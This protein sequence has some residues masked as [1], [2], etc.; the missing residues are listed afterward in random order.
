MVA[1]ESMK[2]VFYIDMEMVRSHGVPYML[3][4][5]STGFELKRRTSRGARNHIPLSAVDN[6]DE[7]VFRPTV[8]SILEGTIGWQ[9]QHI[10]KRKA[11]IYVPPFEVSLHGRQGDGEM[12]CSEDHA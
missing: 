11:H 10:L 3:P 8:Y 1:E 12:L 5:G 2:E 9:N 4:T 7:C 6:L